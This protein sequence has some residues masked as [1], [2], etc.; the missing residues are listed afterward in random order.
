[1]KK[2]IHLLLIFLYI[3]P[4]YGEKTV[5]YFAVKDGSIC[6]IDLNDPNKNIHN[7]GIASGAHPL[8]IQ[9][10]EGSLYVFDAGEQFTYIDTEK[11][12]GDGEVFVINS[13]GKNNYTRE[14]VIENRGGYSSDDFYRGIIVPGT[15]DM[16][17]PDRNLGIRKIPKEVRDIS[18]NAASYL[19]RNEQLGYYSKDYFYGALNGTIQKRGDIWWWCKRYNG[20]GIFRFEESDIKD[21]PG[22]IRPA[23]GAIFYNFYISTF[24]FDDK[25]GYMYLTMRI[26]DKDAIYKI[27]TELAE[28]IS[29]TEQMSL[30]RTSAI[31]ID[32]SPF[33]DEGSM[34]EFIHISQMAVDTIGGYIYWAYQSP[35]ENHKS[36][37]K[38]VSLNIEQ[39]S[40]ADVE[41]IAEGIEAYGI[42]IGSEL[43]TGKQ[44]QITAQAGNLKE[45][46]IQQNAQNASS[47]K[48]KGNLDARDFKYIMDEMRH[49]LS[50][51]DLSEVNITAYR[52]TE[53]TVIGEITDYPANEIPAG[54]FQA[55]FYSPSPLSQI[56]LPNTLES[57]AMKAFMQCKYLHSVIFPQTLKKIN[58]A[59]FGSCE[60][61]KNIELPPS[62]EYLGYAS[63]SNCPGLTEIEIPASVKYLIPGAFR[64]CNNIKSFHVENE[65]KAY[66][67]INGTIFSLDG[68]TLITYPIGK[69][70]T[71]YS[72]PEGV[73]VIAFDAFLCN[74]LQEVTFPE[75]LELIESN[76]FSIQGWGNSDLNI[77]L[78]EKADFSKCINLKTIQSYAFARTALKNLDLSACISLTEIENSA[79]G[80]ELRNIKLPKNLNRIGQYAFQSSVKNLMC[81]AEKPPVCE[82]G[83]FGENNTNTILYIPS[84]SGNS[85]KTANEWKNF[86][87]IEEVN[88]VNTKKNIFVSNAG[89]LSRLLTNDDK[90]FVTNLTVSGTIDARDFKTIQDLPFLNNFSLSE[91]RISAHTGIGGT[92]GA[93]TSYPENE[94]PQDFCKDK[95]I[96]NFI[97]PASVVSIGQNAL[98]NPSLKV[99]DLSGYTNLTTIQR[100]GAFSGGNF[101]TV[102]LPSSLKQFAG[103]NNNDKIKKV[104]SY[105]TVP[106]ETETIRIGSSF[107][108]TDRDHFIIY[109]PKGCKE[110]YRNANG[111]KR[112]TNIIEMDDSYIYPIQEDL[113]TKAWFNENHLIIDSEKG[114]NKITV[115]NMTGKL[116][117]TKI[118]PSNRIS[119]PCETTKGL[120]LVGITFDDN[121][122]Q[123]I[124]VMKQ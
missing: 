31:C 18:I 84:G 61:L 120:Y 11:N 96:E 33:K 100:P 7:T 93:E 115:Y 39:P 28:S 16:Y 73:K 82:T 111:W 44:I 6:Y 42:C 106:P 62:L 43:K 119:L 109:V 98:N 89:S 37:I 118:N 71:D 85:Y 105:S 69:P 63:F 80:F 64:A 46:I 23:A 56:I 4:L 78:L 34:G 124:K 5:L 104:V 45:S 54:A 58:T 55:S 21:Y 48:I 12:K 94:I 76:S 3:F 74:R 113:Q 75:S 14:T 19:V 15:S 103:F 51:L 68:D 102:I 79:F 32:D 110:T 114:I 99:I 90:A 86:T 13:D 52:G 117:I 40:F 87:Q 17:L 22:T 53:G 107:S 122:T 35:D 10:D 36:G 83:A 59:A 81:L 112:F 88:S 77:S 101:H 38:R 116:I 24:A 2:I 25:N 49:K 30:F 65:N 20:S 29:S 67:S 8:T 27:K 95:E 70:E 1:M 9:E 92:V 60:S 121:S 57:I 108:S 91:A 50:F 26:G 41:N 47:L 72:V 97:F 66:K 123:A